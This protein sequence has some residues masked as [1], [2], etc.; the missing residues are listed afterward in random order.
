MDRPPLIGVACQRLEKDT[1]TNVIEW[2][3]NLAVSLGADV[4]N[5]IRN[6][7]HVPIESMGK[8]NER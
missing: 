1:V 2:R 6:R 7:M 3:E 4:A 5:W 8:E